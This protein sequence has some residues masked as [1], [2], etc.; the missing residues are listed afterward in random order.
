MACLDESLE[1]IRERHLHE[2]RALRKR[3]RRQQWSLYGYLASWQ[4][5]ICILPFTTSFD[6]VLLMFAVYAAG[7]LLFTVNLFLR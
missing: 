5:F 7:F 2:L 3:Y 6:Q 4:A 1:E